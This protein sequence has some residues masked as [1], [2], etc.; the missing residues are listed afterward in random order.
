MTSSPSTLAQRLLLAGGFALAAAAIPLTIGLSATA[1]PSAVATC[2]PGETL[3]T[4]SGACKP[5]TDVTTDTT[6]NPLDPENTALQP[7]EI[8]SSAEGDVGELPEVDGIPCTGAGGGGGGTGECIG[9]EESQGN[10]YT[11][12]VVPTASLSPTTVMEQP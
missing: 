1:D 7:D 3:D 8:T 10:T 9:L 12:P 2:P 5:N 4:A 11:K 6:L